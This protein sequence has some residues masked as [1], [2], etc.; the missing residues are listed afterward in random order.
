MKRR[1]FIKTITAGSAAAVLPLSLTGIGKLY[2]Q[3]APPDAVWVSNGEPNDLVA[4]ALKE[5]GGMS[6]FISKGDV[7][8]VKPNIG[9][10]RNPSLAATTNPDVLAAVIKLC[11]E[12][13]AKEVKVF[14]RTCNEPRRCYNN[15]KIEETAKKAGANVSQMRNNKYR[16]IKIDGRM[17]D[18]WEIYEEYLDADK[19]INLPIAKHHSLSKVTLGLK[20]L[21]GVMGGNRGSLHSN[22]S[23]KI[24]DIDRKILPTLNIIDAYRTLVANGPQ[25]GN[26]DHVKLTKTLIASPCIV[27]ADKLALE[28]FGHTINQVEHIR[29]A[30]EQGL[31]KYDPDKANVKRVNLG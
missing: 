20:N 24:V 27:T 4:R 16:E 21:M 22:F 8:V 12:A 10:D 14:D 2:A 23:Q 13:G 17:I 25:G 3:K 6:R 31:A 28:L 5:L 29:L 11:Y 15:S 30:A 9:W 7:V 26:P 1:Y 19:V 18:S